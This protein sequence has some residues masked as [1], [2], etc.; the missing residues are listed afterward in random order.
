M[1]D[2]LFWIN[3]YGLIDKIL[4][5]KNRKRREKEIGDKLYKRIEYQ[6]SIYPIWVCFLPW[7]VKFNEA[8]NSGLIP[9]LGKVICYEGPVGIANPDPN[10]AKILLQ[11]IINDLNSLNLSEF[12]VLALSIGNFL[13]YYVANHFSVKK[14]VSVVPGSKLGACIYDGIASQE[15]RKRAVLLN[16]NSSEEYDL[17][18]AGTNPI[19]NLNNLPADIE[20]HIA[21]HDLFIP[22]IHGEELVQAMI[23]NGKNPK[24]F[25][26]KKGHVLTLAEFGKRNHY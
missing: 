4:A 2:Y 5:K 10:M 8:K 3:D 1:I 18:L 6:T 20:I 26:Y 15:I 11:Q 16:I 13:G 24:I 19:E 21:S 22:T 23:K 9:K 12:N 14:L 17:K 25:R 7:G